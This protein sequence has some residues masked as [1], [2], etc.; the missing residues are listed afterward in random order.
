MYINE[1]HPLYNKFGLEN[2]PFKD[3]IVIIG[4]SLK[5]DHDFRETPYFSYEDN[6]N[7]T[8]G[9]EFHAHAIQQLLDNN[10][11][12]V[13]TK[14]LNLT[15]ESFLYDFLLILLFVIIILYIANN[16]SILV[17]IFSTLI[18][19][20]SWFSFSMGIFI[21]DHFWI[22]KIIINSFYV[23]PIYIFSSSVTD[24]SYLLPVCYPIATIMIT[25]GLNLSYNLFDE[26]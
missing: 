3:K 22:F 12:K 11:I 15:I 21:N 24:T 16:S 26:Q 18:I 14:S 2:S 19:I 6:E 1:K 13:P 20:L 10:Y 25:Y 9:L 4:S 5:E 8:P 23:E 17:S 7:P